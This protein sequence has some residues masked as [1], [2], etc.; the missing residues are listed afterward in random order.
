MCNGE[1]GSVCNS[2]SA[3]LLVV[4]SCLN[5]I[6]INPIIKSKTRLIKSPNTPS[7]WQYIFNCFYSLTKINII[8]CHKLTRIILKWVSKLSINEDLFNSLQST[9]SSIPLRYVNILH[10]LKSNV[11]MKLVWTLAWQTK[12]GRILFMQTTRTNLRTVVTKWLRNCT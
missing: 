11:K 1:L 4:P 10:S 2:D 6:S 5:K 7:T 12:R 3:V 8:A 9:N